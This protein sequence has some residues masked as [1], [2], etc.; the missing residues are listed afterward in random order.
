MRAL[1]LLVLLTPGLMAC[2]PASNEVSSG[3]VPCGA[4]KLQS[5]VGQPLDALDQDSLT[6]P[7]RVIPPNSA[8][9][10]DHR[11]DRLNILV[12]DDDII[13]EISCG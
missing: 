2:K 11:P 13:K 8:V 10:M 6:G 5:F 4:D 7:V 12:N 3:A 9:T 1:V